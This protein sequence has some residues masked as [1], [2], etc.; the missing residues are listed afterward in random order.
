ME[1]ID[2]S[3]PIKKHWRWMY[4]KTLDRDYLLGGPLREEVLHMPVHCFTHIDPP[5]HAV[6]NG[7]MIDEIP[8]HTLIG[9]AKI[10][11]FTDF[12]EN[13]GIS[14]Q[15]METRGANVKQGDIIIIKTCH[16]LKYSLEDKD[17]WFRSPYMQADAGE[18]MAKK[19]IRAAGF[20]FPQDYVLRDFF[21]GRIPTIE[22]MHMHN[23]LLNSGIIQI[24]YLTNLEKI[25]ENEIMLYAIPLNLEKT[26][27]SPARVFAVREDD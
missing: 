18:W 27:G 24:E 14:A 21:I 17:F 8:L 15:D 5:G 1:Y 7:T 2:L 12:P 20:D 19:G 3:Y 25:Q 26:A 23:I 10:L 16:G 6:P 13:T 22:T 11:D 4:H 9:K